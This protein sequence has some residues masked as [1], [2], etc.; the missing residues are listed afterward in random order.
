[1][2]LNDEN[3]VQPDILF[4]SKERLDII[5]EKHIKGAPDLTV[6]IISENSAYRDMVQKKRLYAQ[7]GV[8]EY[9]IV[10]PKEGIVEL[11][12]LGDDSFQ[13]YKTYHKDT[14]LESP[15]LQGLKISLPEIF[16]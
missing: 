1:M 14:V 12:I 16:S 8:K 5:G 2:Y 10:I 3:V 9:W 13:L 15:S 7:F 6:E 4:I 11:Y